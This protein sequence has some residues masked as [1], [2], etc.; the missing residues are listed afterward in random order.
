MK[1]TTPKG[2]AAAVALATLCG[3]AGGAVAQDDGFY[4][5]KTVTIVV[6]FSPGGGYDAYARTVARHM[7]QHIPGNPNV[8]VQN[9]PGAGSL[10]AVRYLDAT[11]AKDGTVVTAFNPG[12][13][14]D[15]L[16]EP[17]KIKVRFTDFAWLGS[18][19]NDFRACYAWH[20]TGIKTWAD[21]ASGRE[22]IMGATGVNTSNY[23]NGAVLRNVFGLKV[24]Q[25]TGFPGS[26]EMRLGI[27]RGE[28][29]GDC[30]SWSSVHPDWL[31][32]K[33]VTPFV[34]YSPRLLPDM[35][36]DLPFIATFAKTD[37]QRKIIEIVIA[38]GEIGRPYIM[39][40]QVPAGRVATMQKAF[41]A[42]MKDGGFVAEA[43]KQD[44]PVNPA[45]ASEAEKILAGVY[46]ATP[47]LIGKARLA[48]K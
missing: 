12:V 32:D 39:S 14:T 5:G 25:I 18:I 10:T 42:T 38:A 24:K 47:E 36:Q 29:H 8:I 4:K 41:T 7:G 40:K 19:T 9:M 37:E 23:V 15:S 34:S 2:A 16:L 45:T 6:G 13:I 11:G 21:L 17:E 44:L 46:A 30:G 3:A 33:K 43:K 27:E 35:P 20:A 22:F 48:I 1:R 31:R 26:N 28:L